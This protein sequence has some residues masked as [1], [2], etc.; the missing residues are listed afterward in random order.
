MNGLLEGSPKTER[1]TATCL[2]QAEPGGL[3]KRAKSH[4]RRE[5]NG[6]GQ[7]YLGPLFPAC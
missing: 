3:D 2:C 4:K 5:R 7:D 6:G 1:H